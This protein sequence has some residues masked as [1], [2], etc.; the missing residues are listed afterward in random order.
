MTVET[1][2][3]RRPPTL[4][5]VP[6]VVAVIAIVAGVT[7]FNRPS[8][9][10]SDAPSGS[11][12]ASGP[13]AAFPPP[14]TPTLVNLDAGPSGTLHQGYPEVISV[15]ALGSA[16]IAGVEVWA[17][18][19]RIA[20]ESNPDPTRPALT[21][22]WEWSPAQAGETVLV[23]RAYDA[24]GRMSQ[25][26]PHRVT[27]V[28][29]PP[30]SY[31]LVEVAAQAGETVEAVVARAGGD[32]AAGPWWN[33][34]LPDGPLPTGTIVAVPILETPLGPTA[35]A[36]PAIDDA[37]LAAALEAP[38][39]AGLATPELGIAID[40]C[41]VTAQASGGT[42]ATDG[43]AFE[44]M[45]PV[46]DTYLK[47]GTVAPT[48]SGT[49]STSFEAIGGQNYA[50]VSAYTEVGTAASAIVPFVMPSECGDD[51]WTGDARLDGGKL[52][53]TG[54]AD[55]AYLYLKIADGEWQRVPSGSGTFVDPIGG[56]FDFNAV[57]PA[58]GS[59][60]LEIEAWGWNAG[61]LVRLGAGTFDAKETVFYSGAIDFG[62]SPSAQGYGTRLD[63]VKP[64][65]DHGDEILDYGYLARGA[66]ATRT[67]QWTSAV[68]GVTHLQWQ[69]LPYP[70]MDS[71]AIAPP[72]LLDSD[73][74]PVAGNTQ[75]TFTLDLKPY[76][77]GT[78]KGVTSVSSWA[79][80][81]IETTVGEGNLWLPPS[82]SPV[83]AYI[84]TAPEPWFAEPSGVPT[85]TPQSP[86]QA[87]LDDLTLLMPP[88]ASLHV[89]VIPYIGTQPAG[90]SSNSVTF[91]I[92]GPNDPF[93]IDAGPT[94][95]PI[96][97][98]KDS[99]TVGVKFFPPTGSSFSYYY[100]VIVVSGGKTVPAMGSPDGKT[101]WNNGTT[102]CNPPKEDDGWSL[103]DAFESFVNWVGTAWD[104]IAQ[105]YDWV[106]EQVIS[107]VLF[108]VPCAELA[109]KV[110]DDGEDVCRK[111]A[112]T[113]LHA[114][115]IAYGIPP[116]IPSWEETIAAAKGDL[117]EYIIASAKTNFPA[118][119]IACD[120][121]NAANSIDSDAPTCEEVVDEAIDE[122]VEQIGLQRSAA[123]GKQANLWI[124]AGV[125]V[126]PHPKSMP[127]PPHFE[128][129]VQRTN[130]ALPGSV[131]CS[132]TGTIDS[133]LTNW[134]WKELVW[135][136][137]DDSV[138]T[139]TGTVSGHPYLNRA[140]EIASMA[141]G[142]LMTYD[143]W[144]TKRAV[145]FE[146]NQYAN[147]YAK[148]Y[149]EWYGAQHNR[150]WVL[151]QK[152]A[153]VKLAVYS[154]CF[155]SVEKTYTLTGNAWD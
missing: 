15:S 87:T 32:P 56:Q 18:G 69:I 60:D 31:Q 90:K 104:Y 23:A 10:P 14:V 107:L 152:G 148:Q 112:K 102:H 110:V 134:S 149:Y 154:N 145:W 123:A 140:Q 143:I 54:T 81:Q 144:L 94:P 47:I 126:E 49:G 24:L 76:I 146:P 108:V 27:V 51:G 73:W 2:A 70:L 106:Q 153:V 41:T 57:L 91:E 43:F 147:W 115:M 96:Q 4:V 131:T 129:T 116:E 150:A 78:A 3:R 77:D 28:S 17:G 84:P 55:R 105:A 103:F 114:V 119:S 82:G 8:P 40:G 39:P 111:L 45:A 38:T 151:V 100:C 48:T 128:V 99:H 50:M 13:P 109:D 26:A 101:D 16:G 65:P 88:L 22:R 130:A 80:Q 138:V 89:R 155:S 42:S 52:V 30:L 25:S 120:A 137:G 33:R 133:T 135:K 67:F 86:S 71:T 72:F 141:P 59:G 79:L 44:V 97:T 12:V 113:A 37:V 75:G 46:G 132:M 74:L 19:E 29:D 66:S 7:F 5:L 121:A 93:P 35:Y 85:G 68:P 136:D 21:A 95:A 11:P 36:D 117:R 142:G 9:D 125:V 62:M 53:F 20:S 1:P 118:L 58:L 98:Y 63:W 61:S 127:Q 64:G 124:P 34:E 6:L 92:G 139:K 83:P 122:A